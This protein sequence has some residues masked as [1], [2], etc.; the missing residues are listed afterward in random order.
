MAAPSGYG[1]LIDAPFTRPDWL[2]SEE[3]VGRHLPAGFVERK[4]SDIV[5][6]HHPF[7]LRANHPFYPTTQKEAHP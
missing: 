3:I 4:A 1:Q 7:R 6:W 2:D 5:T